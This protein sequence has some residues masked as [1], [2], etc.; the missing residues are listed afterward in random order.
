MGSDAAPV[1][2]AP[3]EA[4]DAK[5]KDGKRTLAVL[6]AVGEQRVP[7]VPASS[8]IVQVCLSYIAGGGTL[9]ALMALYFLSSPSAPT[10]EPGIHT[11]LQSSATTVTTAM[12]APL[13]SSAESSSVLLHPVRPRPQS[14]P[15]TIVDAGKDGGIN[16]ERV[17]RCRPGTTKAWLDGADSALCGS[18]TKTAYEQ[19]N[20]FAQVEIRWSVVVEDGDGGTFR[21]IC[22]CISV[23]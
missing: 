22:L 3:S 6:G 5:S 20:Q 23:P 7:R 14:T 2:F 8:R 21:Q 15:S 13:S 16:R 18:P 12:G 19:V 4:Q 1:P 9:A 17:N 11:T 10:A